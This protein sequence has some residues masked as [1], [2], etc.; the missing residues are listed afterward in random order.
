MYILLCANGQYYCGSTTNLDIRIKEHQE[1]RGANFTSK[2]LPVRL[3]YYEVFV[4][5]E[6]A[7][8]REKQVQGWSRAKKEALINKDIE[9]LKKLSECQNLT[10]SK[11]NNT[12]E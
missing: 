9:L 2:H 3:I 11:F 10:A 8:L 1:G 6:D 7:F 4:S 5:V 12:T